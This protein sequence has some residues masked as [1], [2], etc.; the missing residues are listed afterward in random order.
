MVEF[1]ITEKALWLIFMIIVRERLAIRN[2]SE[3]L[4]WRIRQRSRGLT[5]GS[6]ASRRR[7]T[8]L[9][10]TLKLTK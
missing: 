7:R 1:S 6:R 3:P 5:C 9:F 10:I 4:E 8:A 2:V